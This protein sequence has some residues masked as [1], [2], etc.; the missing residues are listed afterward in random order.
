MPTGKKPPKPEGPTPVYV[1]SAEGIHNYA[2]TITAPASREPICELAKVPEEA[3]QDVEQRRMTGSGK[4]YYL[5]VLKPGL[6]WGGISPAESAQEADKPTEGKH[7][8]ARH[9]TVAIHCTQDI[10]SN[11]AQVGLYKLIDEELSDTKPEV[12]DIETARFYLAFKEA[13]ARDADVI[14]ITIV[15]ETTVEVPRD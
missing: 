8:K 12:E 1:D 11:V 10:I 14:H 9:I 4:W 5:I 7:T 13:L 6:T 15:R 2:G 3:V